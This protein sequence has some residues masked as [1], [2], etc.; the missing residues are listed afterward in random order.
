MTQNHS[1]K[2]GGNTL[3]LIV[4]MATAAALLSFAGCVAL[5]PALL[6]GALTA[7]LTA[8]VLR[9]LTLGK[10]LLL[11][12]GLSAV[13]LLLCPSTAIALLYIFVWYGGAFL[14]V[15]VAK[16]TPDLFYIMLYGGFGFLVLTALGMAVVIKEQSGVWDLM[17]IYTTIE[18][19]LL[20][21]LDTMETTYKEL[22]GEQFNTLQPLL[23][24]LRNNAEAFVYQILSL[25]VT[26]LLGL[27]LFTIK[28]GQWISRR[29]SK[30][31]E[32]M[33][34]I[35]YAVPREIT[36]C[37]LIICV[38]SL[39]VASDTYIYA[40]DIADTLMS[41][42]FVLAGIGFVEAFTV[43]KF[44]LFWRRFLKIALVVGAFISDNFSMGIV[45]MLLSVAGMFVSMTRRIIIFKGNEK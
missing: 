19:A 7:P 16:F 10:Q 20:T 1:E 41:W 11:L 3:W 30:P 14:S 9:Q 22:L 15:T 37:Y 34:L 17:S 12:L 25:F 6:L 21:S 5:L 8:A 18:N 29:L 40:L 44:S 2:S 42:L 24:T 23:Q 32:V 31:I 28:V 4:I 33:P 35:F 13:S 26:L 36:F 27:Y 43:K 45:F 39:F 38:I